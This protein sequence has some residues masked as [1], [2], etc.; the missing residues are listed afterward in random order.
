M[1]N[2]DFKTP[3]GGYSFKDDFA[4]RE[5]SRQISDGQRQLAQALD[6]AIARYVEICEGTPMAQ[7][8]TGDIVQHGEMIKLRP[9]PDAR[10]DQFEDFFVWRKGTVGTVLGYRFVSANFENDTKKEATYE[11]ALQTQVLGRADWPEALAIHLK[12]QA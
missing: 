3:A 12:D 11:M 2:P 10:P 4:C 5:L 6:N 7:L 1:M 8:D 9:A